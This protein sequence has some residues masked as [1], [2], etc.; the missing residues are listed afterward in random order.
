[1]I[2]KFAYLIGFTGLGFLLLAVFAQPL[3]VS[4]DSDWGPGRIVVA[5][6]GGVLVLIATF[7]FAWRFAQR[8][9]NSIKGFLQRGWAVLGETRLVRRIQTD[10]DLFGQAWNNSL[11]GRRYRTQIAP[12]IS[13][14]L[15]WFATRPA[16]QYCTKSEDRKAASAAV[17]LGILVLGSYIWFLSVGYWTNWP[18][19]T[20]YYQ[21]LGDAFTHGQVSLLE[22]PD[23]ALLSLSDP[24]LYAN[25]EG[26]SYPWDVV[27]YQGKFYLY[28]GP[29][30]ALVALLIGF[31]TRAVVGDHLLVLVFVGGTFALSTF[32]ILRL[33]SRFFPNLGWA[34][35]IPGILLAGLA[36][37]MPWLLNRPAVYEA[38]I[39]SGQFFLISGFYFGFLALEKNRLEYWKLMLS[40]TCLGLTV[41]SRA[42]LVFV[43]LFLTLMLAG[44]IF[45][46]RKLLQDTH[47]RLAGFIL[48]L[49]LIAATLGWYN[50]AR[51]GD[52]LEFGFK[53]QLT[54]MNT[55]I[56]TFSPA[57][58]L[59]NLH[60]YLLNP[61]RLLSTFPY[62]K[63]ILGGRF[64]FFPIRSPLNY[65]SEH[66][67]GIL[68]TTPFL[69]FALIPVVH[70]IGYTGKSVSGAIKKIPFRDEWSG[71]GLFRWAALSLAGGAFLAFAPILVYIAGMMRFLGDVIPLLVLLSV[72]G[73]FMGR[74]YLEEKSAPVF[75]FNLLVVILTLY[76]ITVSLLLA[77]TGAEARFEHLNP[78]LF[79]KL[80]RWFTP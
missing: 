15:S 69:L 22:E 78:V 80:T 49:T 5:G 39:A 54:G 68:L 35:V 21:Q 48:P 23:S 25:R 36:N 63:P 56:S 55:H 67:A 73:L 65:Y 79:E 58:L 33:R 32:F 72:F 31:F 28:W 34:Y 3:G 74:Q 51:F 43:V 19:T 24:Y 64:I 16:F 37:P 41:A 18:K 6:W 27:F 1:M 66:T 38:A 17:F 70:L 40:S 42:S 61:Y 62:I 30:P 14:S 75:W 7:I 77:V 20:S 13:K 12:G 29:L 71:D 50:K 47:L 60:N 44:Y 59:I 46:H 26:I 4:R 57:N 52:W 9:A 53:Y 2:K 10:L 8:F 45:L 11:P 76:S